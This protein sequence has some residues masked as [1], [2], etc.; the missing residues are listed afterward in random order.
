M[1]EETAQTDI[2]VREAEKAHNIRTFSKG[3]SAK[4]KDPDCI[5]IRVLLWC[6]WWDFFAAMDI[7]VFR[8]RSA[9]RVRAC[10]KAASLQNTA[11]RCFAVAR[12]SPFPSYS[13]QQPPARGGCCFGTSVDNGLEKLIGNRI[14]IPHSIDYVVHQCN[15]LA[16]QPKT[17][18]N[19]NNT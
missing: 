9:L 4:K 3:R 15:M 6:R 8:L 13:K 17:Y 18:Y 12:S 1:N 16:T 10:R 14:R 7:G 19:L 11:L 5:Q 2:R